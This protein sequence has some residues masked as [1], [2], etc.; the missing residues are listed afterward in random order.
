MFGVGRLDLVRTALGAVLLALPATASGQTFHTL[1][2]FKGPPDGILPVGVVI[3]RRS[4][5]HNPFRRYRRY[6]AVP[7]KQL[8][9]QR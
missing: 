7:R 6:C 2:S 9:Q 8:R 1:Y 4:L 5:W 3:D